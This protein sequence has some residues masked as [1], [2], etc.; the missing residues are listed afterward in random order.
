MFDLLLVVLQIR[1]LHTHANAVLSRVL[2]FSLRFCTTLT[3]C[4]QA[5]SLPDMTSCTNS[6]LYSYLSWMLCSVR[7]VVSLLNDGFD[8][9]QHALQRSSKS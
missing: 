5:G 6:P 7:L 8:G 2:D 1:F 3:V 9:E 4:L